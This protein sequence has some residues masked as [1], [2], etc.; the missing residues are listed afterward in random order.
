M[1]TSAEFLGVSVP[2]FASAATGLTLL[3]LTLAPFSLVLGRRSGKRNRDHRSLAW[4]IVVA[5]ALHGA[6]GLISVFVLK[7]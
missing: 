7:A 6:W 2:M 4:V 5:A 1:N 3:L